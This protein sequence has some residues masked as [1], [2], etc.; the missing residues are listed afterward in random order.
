M[1]KTG[2]CPEPEVPP[3]LTSRR[4]EAYT[5]GSEQGDRGD[6]H[7]CRSQ[8]P[9]DLGYFAIH[10]VA[11]EGATARDKHDNHEEGCG[12]DAIEDRNE[13][14][15]PDRIEVHEAQRGASDCAKSNEAV[16][17]RSSAYGTREPPLLAQEAGHAD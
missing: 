14:E 8:P 15:Q 3:G 10:V 13:D 16:E 7:Q 2:P 9:E 12:G 6:G 1:A 11:H 5:T 17:D 4:S